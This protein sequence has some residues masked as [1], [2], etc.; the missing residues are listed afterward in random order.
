MGRGYEVIRHP[1]ERQRIAHL[2]RGGQTARCAQ[3]L[4]NPLGKFP[5]MNT[6]EARTAAA[7]YL[8]GE[9]ALPT[10]RGALFEKCVTR[11]LGRGR[12]RRGAPVRAATA[13]AYRFALEEVA[14]PLHGKQIS[15]IKRSDVAA[16]LERA[17]AAH[18]AA[19]ASLARSV[20]VR[21]FNW[22][23]ESG[24]LETN[25]ARGT[26]IYAA[27]KGR[28]VLADGELKALWHADCNSE[29]RCILRLCLLL[30][31]RRGEIGGMRWSELDLDAGLWRLPGGRTKNHQDR[32]L[33]L[34][35]VALAEIRGQPRV[36]GEDTVFGSGNPLGYTAWSGHKSKL[37]RQLGFK[38]PWVVHDLRRTVRTRLHALGIPHE[39]VTRILGHGI[40]PLAQIYDHSDYTPTMR[41]ALEQWAAV[42]DRIAAQPAA[43]VI[44]LG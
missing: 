39:V 33:P 6:A 26:P 20:L 32:Q 22:M 30:G 19:S 36:L 16:T 15:K 28:R 25:P 18:G 9:A 17:D 44:A 43:E 8:T 14:K 1:G 2:D 42:V 12:T 7:P 27:G 40:D 35:P 5:Q 11:F 29:Y 34:P 31:A 3:Q 10:P 21:F 23:I 4:S 41:A 24:E 37:D 13:R 38:R